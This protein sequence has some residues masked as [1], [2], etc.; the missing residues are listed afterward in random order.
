[1]TTLTVQSLKVAIPFKE[2]TLPTFDDADPRVVID[3]GGVRIV[4]KLNPKACRKASAHRGGGVLQGRLVAE[5]GQ[6]TLVD[7]GFQ[8]FEPKPPDA[9]GLAATPPVG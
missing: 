7:A 5:R 4:G 2:G 3:L 9:P 8:L 6:L 1:M